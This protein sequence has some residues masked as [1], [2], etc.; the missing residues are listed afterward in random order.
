MLGYQF[1][2]DYPYFLPCFIAF[3]IAII[4]VFLGFIFLEEVRSVLQLESRVLYHDGESHAHLRL[5]PGSATARNAVLLLQAPMEIVPQ[6][7]KLFLR[8]L[9]ALQSYYRYQ[10]YPLWH[11]LASC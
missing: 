9:L 1:L 3:V 2:K 6:P 4:G 7:H 11:Y 10:S 8:N 5:C